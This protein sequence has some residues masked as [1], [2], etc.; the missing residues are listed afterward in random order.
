[1]TSWTYIV[2][3]SLGLA[4]GG[5]MVYLYFNKEQIAR[6]RHQLRASFPEAPLRRRRFRPLDTQEQQQ[7]QKQPPK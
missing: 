4:L 3:N 5:S 1:M 7:Q 2:L 6:E